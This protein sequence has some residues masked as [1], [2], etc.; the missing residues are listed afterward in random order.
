MKPLYASEDGVLWLD[1]SVEGYLNGAF[2]HLDINNWST[3]KFKFYLK[4]WAKAQ[5][6][7][8]EDGYTTVY[9]TT[10][11]ESLKLIKMFGL[12]ET[13]ITVNGYNLLRKELCPQS[14]SFN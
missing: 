1:T 6:L 4:V 9:S 7:L 8:I 5:E 12:K 11:N 2:V 13:G 14:H 10:P 3:S